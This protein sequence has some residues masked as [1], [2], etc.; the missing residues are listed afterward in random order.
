MKAFIFI[1]FIVLLHITIN[2]SAKVMWTCEP[3]YTE[4][5]NVVYA[6]CGYR[7]VTTITMPCKEQIFYWSPARIREV[8]KVCKNP[9]YFPEMKIYIIRDN[10]T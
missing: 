7:E 9:Q 10:I 3:H 8:H 6:N 5:N 1:L 4:Q 2:V